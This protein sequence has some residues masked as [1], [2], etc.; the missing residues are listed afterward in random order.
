[1]NINLSPLNGRL[2]GASVPRPNASGALAGHAAGEP[3][4]KL[5]HNHLVELFP[6]NTYSQFEY[7]NSLY[8]SHP[9]AITFRQRYELIKSV[10]L[11]FLLDRGEA[12]TVAWNKNNQYIE[13]QNDTADSLIFNKNI[14]NI[15]DIKTTSTSKNGQPPNIISAYKLATMCKLMLDNNDFSSFDIIYI[16]IDWEEKG[17]SLKCTDISIRGL[18]N[19]N[20]QRLYINWAAALQIQFHVDSLD[21]TYKGSIEQWCNDYLRSY[22]SSARKRITT[23]QTKFIDPFIT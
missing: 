11:A 15:I 23:M 21:Q 20:P 9:D 19:T 5:V 7:L 14:A 10:P 6:G 2:I 22:L 8:L 13:K 12:P 18:F 4:A 3:F 17:P 16:G 1:M